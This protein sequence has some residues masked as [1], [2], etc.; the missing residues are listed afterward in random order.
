MGRTRR[1]LAVAYLHKKFG[2]KNAKLN[3]MNNPKRNRNPVGFTLIELLVVI[4]I[5]AILAAMLLPA[6]AAA[7][8]RAYMVNCTSNLKQVGLAIRMF[9]DD[10]NDYLPNA[11]DGLSSNRG[12]SVGQQASYCA[13]P[14]SLY[15]GYNPKDWL[16]NYMYAY[17][18]SP[19]PSASTNVMKI[20]F[21]PANEH[22]NPKV[23]SSIVGFNCYQMVEGNAPGNTSRY[24]GL[25]LR[26]TG[27]NNT[28]NPPHKMSEV[29]AAGSP[30]RIWL[31]V[32][33]DML[34]NNGIGGA[35]NWSPDKPPHVSQRNYLWF[36]GHVEPVKLPPAGTGD[37]THP[38]PYDQWKH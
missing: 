3:I 4:A 38:F 33:S 17:A 1:G 21:C 34:G 13:T 10:N 16:A 18:G 15:A 31:M 28:G 25:S 27:Y 37:S 24:C 7:K 5:I 30:S 36:D 8:R 12:L 6:L 26:P 23:V 9:V 19:D 29:E 32:D 20:L 11:A 35:S 2:M 14:N 22:Y